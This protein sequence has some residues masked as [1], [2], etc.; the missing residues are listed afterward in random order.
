MWLVLSAAAGPLAAPAQDAVARPGD[1]TKARVWVENRDPSEALP[2]VVHEVATPVSVQ[3]VGPAP[4]TV[5]VAGTPT[6]AIAPTTTV[7]AR[8]VRQPWEYRTINVKS[9]QDM[10]T[11]LATAGAEGWEATGVQAANQAGIAILLKRPK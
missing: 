2:V 7:Q 4:V 5:Q 1:P 8:L 11:L 3:V 10:A 6:V 9:P